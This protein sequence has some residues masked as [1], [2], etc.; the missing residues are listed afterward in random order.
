MYKLN[1]FK[2]DLVRENSIFGAVTKT[3][4]KLL[5]KKLSAKLVHLF[6]LDCGSLTMITQFPHFIIF[7]FIFILQLCPLRG[8]TGDFWIRILR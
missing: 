1:H 7:L 5:G 6:Y 2:K 8:P 4:Q 3:K